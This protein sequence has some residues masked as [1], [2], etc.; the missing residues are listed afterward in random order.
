MEF[1]III[2]GFQKEFNDESSAAEFVKDLLD[3]GM[4]YINADAVKKGKGDAVPTVFVKTN[5]ETWDTF[6]E[7][8]DSLND[9]ASAFEKWE[10]NTNIQLKTIS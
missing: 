5:V 10:V 3:A 1:R 6:K 8:S 2:S 9:Y 7:A 4:Y